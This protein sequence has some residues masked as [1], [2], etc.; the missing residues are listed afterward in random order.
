MQYKEQA[1]WT[2][3]FWPKSYCGETWQ[4]ES[5]KWSDVW[6]AISCSGGLGR[7]SEVEVLHCMLYVKGKLDCT[8]LDVRDCIVE[9]LWVKV[10][11]INSKADVIIGVCDWP[12][13]QQREWAILLWKKSMDQLSLSFFGDYLPIYKLGIFNCCEN[14]VGA[15]GRWW[16]SIKYSVFLN[17][18]SDLTYMVT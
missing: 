14:Q 5:Y 7:T 6:R 2:G 11:G 1:A 18:F 15:M 17:P 3:R 10:K 9:S 8:D 16:S 13:T 4:H 12:P